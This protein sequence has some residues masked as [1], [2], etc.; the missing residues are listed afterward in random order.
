MKRLLLLTPPL[1][2]TN[3]PYP[4]TMH[5]AGFL[6]SLG[7]EVSQCDLSIK[8]VRDVLVEYGGDEA[9]ELLRNAGFKSKWILTDGGFTEVGI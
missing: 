4:A 1:L 2:Q 6:R 5:L 7:L 9:E 3:S 8:V